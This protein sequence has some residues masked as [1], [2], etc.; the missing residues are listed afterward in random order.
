LTSSQPP[1]SNEEV[2]DDD[3]D[4][5][6]IAAGPEPGRR[7]PWPRAGLWPGG[8][9]WLIILAETVA[10]AVAVAVAVHYHAQARAPHP[11]RGPAASV[12]TSL[13]MPEMTTV[14]LALPADGTVTGTVVITAAALPG[15]GLVEFTVSAVVTGGQPGT[16]YDL[17]GNDCSTTAPLPD[18]VW[19]TGVT[20]AAGVAHL[21][22]YAWTGAAADRYWL[23]LDPSPVNPPP[24]L[25]GQFAQGQAASFPAGQ[26]PCAP[27]PA[28]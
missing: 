27:S 17:D 1:T 6:L 11:G 16:V 4:A 8:L 26:A 18:H 19:A 15:A 3:A 10:L 20:G 23:A 14:A 13:P 24:G 9:L 22:G 5:D 21:V 2:P 25:R 12:T 28:G 7:P